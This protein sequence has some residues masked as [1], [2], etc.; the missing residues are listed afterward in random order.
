M[1]NEWFASA[2][3]AG[4]N[5]RFGELM[6]ASSW[7]SAGMLDSKTAGDGDACL[8]VEFDEAEDLTAIIDG[9]LERMYG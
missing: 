5:N 3:S 6:E 2:P 7:T 4:P 8:D 9:K 1:D